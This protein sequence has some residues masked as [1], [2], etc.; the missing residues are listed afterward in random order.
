MNTY[1]GIKYVKDERYVDYTEYEM[2]KV[3]GRYMNVLINKF[4]Q[5]LAWSKN[6]S[7]LSLKILNR[8]YIRLVELLNSLLQFVKNLNAKSHERLNYTKKIRSNLENIITKLGKHNEYKMDYKKLNEY[9]TKFD[10]F[11]SQHYPS[12]VLVLSKISGL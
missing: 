6:P 7:K 8:K 11:S 10:S 9:W 2:Y 12:Q 1:I 4:L 5:Q 3:Y